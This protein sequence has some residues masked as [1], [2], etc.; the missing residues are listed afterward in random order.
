MRLTTWLILIWTALMGVWAIVGVGKADCGSQKTELGQSACQA[1]AGIGV[2]VIFVI[3]LVGFVILALIA[4]LT[5]PRDVVY[6]Q[7]S[8]ASPQPGAAPA[9]WYPD[10]RDPSGKT[11]RYFDGQ[12]WTEHVHRYD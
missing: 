9:N 12:R 8:P 2:T 6:V 4:L 5:K 1:G 7:Q 11:M 10:P 3:W